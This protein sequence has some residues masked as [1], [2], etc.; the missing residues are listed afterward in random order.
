MNLLNFTDPRRIENFMTGAKLTGGAKAGVNSLALGSIG[1]S[2]IKNSITP[3]I[4]NKT[5]G[6]RQ[7]PQMGF[8][9]RRTPTMGANGALTL[10]LSKFDSR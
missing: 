1:Y 8:D 10:A 9:M 6:I 3:Q 4:G 2:G 5:P 7:A